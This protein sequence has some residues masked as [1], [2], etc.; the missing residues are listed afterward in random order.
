MKNDELDKK[1]KNKLFVNTSLVIFLCLLG[2][3][4][5]FYGMNALNYKYDI[6]KSDT[7]SRL[8][9]LSIM[10]IVSVILGAIISYFVARKLANPINQIKEATHKVAKG[11]FDIKLD[12][13]KN[14]SLNELIDDFNKMTEELKSIETLKTDFISGVS[15]EFK[16]PLSVIQSYSKALRKPNIDEETRKKYEKVIDTNIQKLTNLTNNILS[17]TK[18]ENQQIIRD[19]C[20]FLIDEQIRQCI[21][22]L[23]PEWKEKNIE[24]DLDLTPIQYYGSKSLMAQVWQNLIDNAI[25]Y[26]NNEGKIS[27]SLKKENEKIIIKISDNGI[28]MNEETQKHIF[29]KFYQADTSRS[30]SG[31]GLGLA[32]VS[33]ILEI[34]NGSIT[35]ESQ[36]N[37]GSTFTVII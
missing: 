35:V 34:S 7:F 9:S 15:H 11:N 36:E 10:L 5:F 23:E 37:K 27:I 4:L 3:L 31:N 29:D 32:I 22:S 16:T 19:E 28:G 2:D 18:I 12:N 33:K 21:V 25:K 1:K 26:S 8:L 6:L 24:F 13:I 17:L 20:E 14:S 30:S